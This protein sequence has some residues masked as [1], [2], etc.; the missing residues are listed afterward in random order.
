V[1]HGIGILNL[2]RNY[3]VFKEK[4]SA[5]LLTCKF[6]IMTSIFRHFV[7]NMYSDRKAY[8]NLSQHKTSIEV[9][10]LGK[11]YVETDGL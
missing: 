2:D 1:G 6:K 3:L 4:T 10:L 7:I 9:L 5:K 8:A 11:S